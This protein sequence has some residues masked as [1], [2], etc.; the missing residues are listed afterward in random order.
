M[1]KIIIFTI[2][3]LLY[4]LVIAAQVTDKD[5]QVYK[6]VAVNSKM[7]MAENLNVSHFRNGNIIPQVKTKEAW[8][9][10]MNENKPAWCHYEFDA[11][12]GKK[13][14]KLYNGYAVLDKRGLASEGW[15]VSTDEEWTNLTAFLGVH[16]AGKKLK[17][18]SGWELKGT[19]N[20]GTNE[21]GFTALPGGMV[22]YWG[23]SI[24]IGQNA[25]F[26]TATVIEDKITRSHYYR[27]IDF[28]NVLDVNRGAQHSGTGSSVR[29]VKN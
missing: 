8:E 5:G 4:P 21:S 15:H 3:L 17:A 14:G 20:N 23:V 16:D 11:A 2:I 24:A 12:M 1:K 22:M 6:T 18:T 26:W 9:K 28:S 25:S 29:C 7:W 10:A 27:S 13:Y 19:M